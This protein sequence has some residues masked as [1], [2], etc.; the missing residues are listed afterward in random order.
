MT[1]GARGMTREV[2]RDVKI[3]GFEGVSVSVDGLRA[4]HDALRRRPGGASTPQWLA[5]RISARPG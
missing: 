1:T 2:A 4:T 3:A 5:L